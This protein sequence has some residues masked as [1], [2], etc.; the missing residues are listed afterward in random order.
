MIPLPP[1]LNVDAI[2][3]FCFVFFE[4]MLCR[5]DPK[6]RFKGTSPKYL[7]SSLFVYSWVGQVGVL[8]FIVLKITITM[9]SYELLVFLSFFSIKGVIPSNI[10]IKEKSSL[11]LLLLNHCHSLYFEALNVKIAKI[12]Y[13]KNCSKISLEDSIKETNILVLISLV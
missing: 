1:L 10:K 8:V 13:S 7:H 12:S 4:C 5:L 11:I 9:H 2:V 3:L 6:V